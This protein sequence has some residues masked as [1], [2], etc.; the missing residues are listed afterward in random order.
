MGTI[1]AGAVAAG[2]GAVDVGAVV[3]GEV[4]A[5]TG[6]VDVGAIVAGE[7]AADSCIWS[8]TSPAGISPQAVKLSGSAALWALMA[9]EPVSRLFRDTPSSSVADVPLEK[10]VRVCLTPPRES[11]GPEWICTNPEDVIPSVRETTT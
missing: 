10:L 4:A 5:G 1:V 2:T 3:A 8:V 7:V 6:A 11:H 9:R